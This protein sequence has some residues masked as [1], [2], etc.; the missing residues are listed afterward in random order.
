M[1]PLC[2]GS[3]FDKNSTETAGQNP[4]AVI[5]SQTEN[6]NFAFNITFIRTLTSFIFRARR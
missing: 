5:E 2:D 4:A 6:G 1:E 3:E